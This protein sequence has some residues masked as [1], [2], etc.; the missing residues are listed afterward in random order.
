MTPSTPEAPAAQPAYRPLPTG[1][2]PRWRRAAEGL[3]WMRY[4]T[5]A[6]LGLHAVGAFARVVALASVSDGHARYASGMVVASCFGGVDLLANGVLAA[7]LWRFGGLPPA[8]GAAPPA[9]AAFWLF[10]AALGASMLGSWTIAPLARAAGYSPSSIS[11]MFLLRGV[12]TIA[13]HAAYLGMLV[14]ALD[15]SMRSVGA[16]LP[17]WAPQA[18]AAFVGWKVLS[19]PAQSLLLMFQRG[20][21]NYPWMAISLAADVGFAV[22]LV[23]LLRFA[24]PVLARQ[25]SPDPAG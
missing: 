24:E 1:P 23:T 17:R 16:A 22:A 20:I 7:G 3:R 14:R 11:A 15:V 12:V 8:T 13:L 6:S 21:I 5:W 19:I 18:V 2:S 9:R 10:V 4:A 25:E